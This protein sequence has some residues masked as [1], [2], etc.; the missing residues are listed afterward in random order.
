MV[1]LTTAYP[2]YYATMN[3]KERRC[4]VF[5]IDAARLDERRLYPDEDYLFHRMLQR[6]GKTPTR[7]QHR[8]LC[9]DLDLFQR[10]WPNSLTL[11][12]N[13]AY[14]GTIPR[15]AIT[16][17]CHFDSALRPEL[18]SYCM[19]ASISF[20]NYEQQGKQFEKVVAWF[21]GDRKVLPM[22]AE[23]ET[24]EERQF[25]VAQ[26]KDR[27]GIEVVELRQPSAVQPLQSDARAT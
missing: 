4:V 11:L 5:E 9:A 16:R 20:A 14:L 22:V 26:S 13:C 7:E 24:A 10:L 19:D 23:A 3:P 15:R 18:A 27:T 6:D 17:Y 1:Y 2:F 21:F 12:G 8:R 25:W